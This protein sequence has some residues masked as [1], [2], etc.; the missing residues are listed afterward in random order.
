MIRTGTW[1]NERLAKVVERYQSN[2]EKVTSKYDVVAETARM[3]CNV[4][5]CEMWMLTQMWEG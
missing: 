5:I 1:E 2:L 4:N 3:G